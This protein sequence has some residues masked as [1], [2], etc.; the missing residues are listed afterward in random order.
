[1]DHLMST[2]DLAAAE[3]VPGGVFLDEIHLPAQHLLELLAHG[4]D[5][6]EAPRRLPVEGHQHV[7][8]AFRREVLPQDRAEYRELLNPPLAAER[9]QGVQRQMDACAWRLD[10]HGSLSRLPSL[11]QSGSRALGPPGTAGVL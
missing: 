9:I 8:I 10:G 7:H 3:G 1:M 6:P 5:V 4:D 11:Y 2:E